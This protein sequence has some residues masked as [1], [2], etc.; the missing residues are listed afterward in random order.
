MTLARIG[1][2]RA[3]AVALATALAPGPALAESLPVAL[4]TFDPVFASDAAVRQVTARIGLPD[5]AEVVPLDVGSPW[6]GYELRAYY[7]RVGE[8]LVFTRADLSGGNVSILRYQGPIPPAERVVPAP[9]GAG[10]G[11]AATIGPPDGASAEMDPDR[12]A[13]EAEARAAAAERA[14]DRA[15]EIAARM[16]QAFKSSLGKK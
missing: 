6:L 4:P 9:A 16:D 12:A 14:A 13:T 11:P 8:L 10:P 7:D 1:V 2:R 15:E 3:L 5:R